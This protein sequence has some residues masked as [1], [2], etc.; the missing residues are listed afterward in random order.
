MTILA[1][2]PDLWG[3]VWTGNICQFMAKLAGLNASK[4]FILENYHLVPVGFRAVFNL[5]IQCN[6]IYSTAIVP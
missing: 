3:I 2:W 6:I 1:F 4:T 5:L